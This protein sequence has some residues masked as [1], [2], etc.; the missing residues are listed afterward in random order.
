MMK[1]SVFSVLFI[2]A[3]IVA[4]NAQCNEYYVMQDGSSWEYQT[5]NPKGKVTGKNQ[6]TVTA[7]SKNAN[8]YI[9]TVNSIML[10]D[11]GKEVMKGDLEFKCENG[12]MFMDMRNF[13]SEEQLKAFSSYEMKVEATSLQIPSTLSAGESLRD[14]KL[15]ITATGAPFPM[16][17]IV[18]ITDRKVEA[19]E[20]ITTPAGTF[21]CFKI[22]SKMI[23]ENHM[24]VKITNQMATVEWIAPKVGTVKSESFNK[25][26]SAGYTVLSKRVN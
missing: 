20:T 10:D 7:F 15:T 14:G 8:G 19:K 3:S 24:G 1:K 23:L 2:L 16:K 5:F 9:A 13:I 12:T 18:T 6:Q 17:M 4:A 21:D 22:T 11:K 26:K 25:G